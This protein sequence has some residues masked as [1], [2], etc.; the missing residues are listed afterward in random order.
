MFSVRS[1]VLT[2]MSFKIW[3]MKPC[4]GRWGPNFQWSMLPLSSG[5]RDP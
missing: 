2:A 3:S 4:F 5:F 1:E